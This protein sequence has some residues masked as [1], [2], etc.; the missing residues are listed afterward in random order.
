MCSA[1]GWLEELLVENGE[2][3]KGAYSNQGNL[4]V[5]KGLTQMHGRHKTRLKASV[6]FP[7][8]GV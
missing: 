7:A 8:D 6:L 2:L 3:S 5:L 1:E 4:T